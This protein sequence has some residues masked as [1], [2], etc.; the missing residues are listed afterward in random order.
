MGFGINAF[1]LANNLAE[2]GVTGIAILLKLALDW[3]PGIVTLLI[4]IP[5][6]LIGAKI[7]GRA[8]LSYTIFG[9][10][11][12]SVFL[13]LFGRFRYPMDDLLL[14]SLFAGVSVGAGLGIIFR[15]GGTTGGID[16][17]ARIIQKYLG[18]KMGR[19]MLMAD[20]GVLAISLVYLSIQQIMYTM[21]AVFVGSR[22]IDFMQEVGYSARAVLIVSDRG[23]DIAHDITRQMSRG[24]T[25]LRG[26]GAYTE[27][28]KTVVY[29]VVG[30][31]EL[32]KLKA[33]IFA[34]D[35]RAFVSV[36]ETNEVLGEGFSLER[37]SVPQA[38]RSQPTHAAH[39]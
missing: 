8:A 39:A 24:A 13:W 30:R 21:V 12:L 11:C 4:N 27:D 5:L 38:A 25:L 7:L 1:N 28:D 16:I 14:A 26:T 15:Y 10:V 31:S 22:I 32:V 34:R 6:F 23:R 18:W 33:V 36:S 20:A 35:P 29:V 2:G 9:T 37:S 3:D 17:I 19:T